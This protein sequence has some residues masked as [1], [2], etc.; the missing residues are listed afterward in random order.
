[1]HF[2]AIWNEEFV[3]GPESIAQLSEAL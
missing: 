1:M 2:Y 3:F